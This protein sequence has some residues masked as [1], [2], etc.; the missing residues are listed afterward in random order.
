M[1]VVRVSPARQLHE[2][3]FRASI[4][5][6][7]QHVNRATASMMACEPWLHEASPH[8]W[9]CRVSKTSQRISTTHDQKSHVHSARSPCTWM[10]ISVQ[11]LQ[12]SMQLALCVRWRQDKILGSFDAKWAPPS[13]DN[14]DRPSSVGDP[15]QCQFPQASKFLA[16]SMSPDKKLCVDFSRA[17]P[18]HEDPTK[19]V[20]QSFTFDPPK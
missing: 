15:A 1:S 20:H 13:P 11:V 4:A 6:D 19:C 16:T 2:G 10:T 18:G 8:C 17:P 7:C 12:R 14:T 5:P 3:I 9:Y